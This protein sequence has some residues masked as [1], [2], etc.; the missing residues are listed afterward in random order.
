MDIKKTENKLDFILSM[1]QLTTEIKNYEQ[2]DYWLSEYYK[3]YAEYEK[4]LI[5]RVKEGEIYGGKKNKDSI[6]MDWI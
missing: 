3:L 6:T 1:I 4:E 2:A 5:K